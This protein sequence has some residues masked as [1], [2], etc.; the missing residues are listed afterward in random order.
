MTL[1]APIYDLVILLDLELE[2][3]ARAKIVAD[4]RKSIEAEGELLRHDP[5]GE[6]ALAYPIARK[7]SAEYHLLQFHAG[8]PKLLDGLEHS[9]RIIDGI[10]RFRI[11]KLAPGVPEAPDM[12]ASSSSTPSSSAPPPRRGESEPAEGAPAQTEAASPP[13]QPAAEPEPPAEQEQAAEQ[14]PAAEVEAAEVE[15]GE[16]A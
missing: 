3:S 1:P 12:R 7:A 5:W 13:E 10:L 6:R 15:A 11:I 14:P 9:L 2:E 4:A 16:T 8:S